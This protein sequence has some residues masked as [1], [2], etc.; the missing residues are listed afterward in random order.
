[1]THRMDSWTWDPSLSAQ[2]RI[3]SR[4]LVGKE[5]WGRQLTTRGDEIGVPKGII[6]AAQNEP[7]SGVP[8]MVYL[9]AGLE[10]ESTFPYA[11]HQESN[12]DSHALASQ[13]SPCH[14][15]W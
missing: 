1:M 4:L 13:R 12:I 3:G 14:S 6:L 8:S 7:K 2:L 10:I 15:A 11:V 5:I 9:H